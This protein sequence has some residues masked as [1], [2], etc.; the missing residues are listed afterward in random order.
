MHIQQ[1][2]GVFDMGDMG[3]AGAKGG[4]GGGG[5]GNNMDNVQRI[6]L[7]GSDKFPRA[8]HLLASRTACI[9]C[10]VE[11]KSQPGHLTNRLGHC[12][13]IDCSFSHGTACQ[14]ATCLAVADKLPKRNDRHC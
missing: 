6:L 13:H 14:C 8:N 12:M 1:T 2:L 10:K 3:G 4:G 7:L 5:G 11:I 9:S